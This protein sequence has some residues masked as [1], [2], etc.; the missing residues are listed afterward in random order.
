MRERPQSTADAPPLSAA[1]GQRFRQ[2]V[3]AVSKSRAAPLC[4][5]CQVVPLGMGA[6]W[7]VPLVIDCPGDADEIS[8]TREARHPDRVTRKIT[9]FVPGDRRYSL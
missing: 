6:V 3:E 7:K 4:H 2:H 9:E 8:R 1:T 5:L